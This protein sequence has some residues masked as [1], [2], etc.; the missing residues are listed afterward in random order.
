M[1][2]PKIWPIAS[3]L[4]RSLGTDMDRSATYDFLLVFHSNYDPVSYTVSEIGAM[5]AKISEPLVFNAPTEGFPW[6]FVMAVE[7]KKN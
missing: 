5:F 2:T 3:R 4:L 6:N 1:D 7:V